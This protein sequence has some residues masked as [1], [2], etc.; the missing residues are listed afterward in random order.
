[1][2]GS[3]ATRKHNKM[4][5]ALAHFMRR[6][7]GCRSKYFLAQRHFRVQFLR[8]ADVRKAPAP[9]QNLAH[10]F[11]RCASTLNETSS[12][13]T[14]HA[15]GA[16]CGHRSVRPFAMQPS[17]LARPQTGHDLDPHL[18]AVPNRALAAPSALHHFPTLALMSASMAPAQS[19]LLPY[20]TCA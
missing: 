1:M 3:V 19:S 11:R 6:R 4:R 14:V 5:L 2:E 13:F 15:H 16:A 18:A 9:Y 17:T 12:C 8:I 10:A 20:C 7:F